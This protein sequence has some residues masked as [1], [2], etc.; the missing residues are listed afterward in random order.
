MII[1]ANFHYFPKF[2]Y[3]NLLLNKYIIDVVRSISL[4]NVKKHNLSIFGSKSDC[5]EEIDIINIFFK[6]K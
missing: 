2:S 6:R 4:K 5:F 3:K 1:F